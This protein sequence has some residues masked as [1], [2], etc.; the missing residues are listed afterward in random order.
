MLHAGR[1]VINTFRWAAQRAVPAGGAR[2]TLRLAVNQNDYQYTSTRTPMFDNFA[3]Y[4]VSAGSTV[5]QGSS[6]HC[7]KRPE[8]VPPQHQ[9]LLS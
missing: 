2:V 6:W 4:A 3:A 7:R 8:L 1:L 9:W 5:V